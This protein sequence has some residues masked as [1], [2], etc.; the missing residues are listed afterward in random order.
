MPATYRARPKAWRI[1]LAFVI[2][3]GLASLALACALPLYAGLPDLWDRIA[4]TAPI[5]AIFGAYPPTIILGLP[6]YLALKERLQPTVLNCAGVG[7]VTAAL[8]SLVLNLLANP[9]YA[10]SGGHVTHSNGMRTLWGW[11][12]LATG[13]GWM[14][15]VGA[16]TG[17]A[18]W[19]VAVC[20]TRLSR[21]LLASFTPGSDL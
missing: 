9:T 20:G 21:S 1:A 6:L 2:T 16:L 19:L 4:R 12:D 18:F 13:V 3:P 7:A 10:Y 5:Y 15:L 11:F 8:P 17:A 14:A